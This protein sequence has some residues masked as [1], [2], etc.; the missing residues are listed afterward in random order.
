MTQNAKSEPESSP[1]NSLEIVKLAISTSITVSIFLVGILLQAQ[2]SR[3]ATE[4]E[5]AI[6][7]QAIETA[8]YSKLLEQRAAIWERMAMPMTR[9]NL[10]LTD[11]DRSS[12]T[13]RRIEELRQE[14]RQIGVAYQLYF[15]ADFVDASAG[16]DNM[17][18]LVLSG[19]ES[20]G[21]GGRLWGRYRCMRWAAARDLGIPIDEMVIG[22]ET[23]LPPI[24]DWIP[25]PWSRHPGCPGHP[26]G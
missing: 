7:R 5:E 24:L 23:S 20:A 17:V 10:L 16:Y 9:L 6:R 22:W 19:R 15:S 8:R 14:I 21:Y 1:W 13:L 18:E 26:L 4:R 25:G 3:L 11:G 2:Q 12:G